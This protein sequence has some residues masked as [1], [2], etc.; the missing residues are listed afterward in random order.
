MSGSHTE[1]NYNKNYLICLLARQNIIT[2]VLS[3][4]FILIKNGAKLAK[5]RIF[6]AKFFTPA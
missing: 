6:A 1:Q 2:N 3:D 5:K 4:Q